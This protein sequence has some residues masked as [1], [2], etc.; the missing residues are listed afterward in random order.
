MPP[1]AYLKPLVMVQPVVVSNE[2]ALSKENA[3]KL[4]SWADRVARRS[5]PTCPCVALTAQRTFM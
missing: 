1:E 4:E 3:L 5:M 2:G